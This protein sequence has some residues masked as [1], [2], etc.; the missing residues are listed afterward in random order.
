MVSMEM[1]S[2][3]P[4]S[5]TVRRAQQPPHFLTQIWM[6]IKLNIESYP[7]IFSTIGL[8]CLAFFMYVAV[9]YSKPQ[10]SRHKMVEDYSKIKLDYDFKATQIDNWCLF[11]GDNACR[12]ED[13]TEPIPRDE[14]KGWLDSHEANKASIDPA[15]EYDIVFLGDDLVEARNGKFLGMDLPDGARI[16]QS[17]V[18]TFGAE[19]NDVE[20]NALALGIGGDS[21]TNLLWRISHGEMPKQLYSKLFWISIGTNDLAR[22]GCSEEA[23]VL[24][25]LRVAEEVYY[26][27]PGSDVVIQGILPRSSRSDGSL[28][29]TPTASRIPLFGKKLSSKQQSEAARRNF[30][31]WPSIKAINKEL[32][33]FC[34]NHGKIIYFDASALFLG[35]MSNSLYRSKSEQIMAELMP[36][37]VNPSVNGHK[38][39]NKAIQQEYINIVLDEHEENDIEEKTGSGRR[40]LL[41]VASSAPEDSNNYSDGDGDVVH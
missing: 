19:N 38:I 17:F 36:N 15:K 37:Y 33:D 9:E 1:E 5:T 7:K 3:H 32:E 18:D 34:T 14:V 10:M 20:I 40:A 27:N 39:L 6:L 2:L 28:A 26:N 21:S 23:T 25:I 41:R 29:P 31:L 16:K 22:G 35:S 30:Q 24:G 11:G 4:G 12:C 8:L 13:F